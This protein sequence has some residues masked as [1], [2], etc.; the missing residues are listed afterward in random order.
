M[1]EILICYVK[2]DDNL[3]EIMTKVLPSGEKR[4]TLVEQLLYNITSGVVE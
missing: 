2:T 3:A 4:V 1:K